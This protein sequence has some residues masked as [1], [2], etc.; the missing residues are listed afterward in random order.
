LVEG[1]VEV[2]GELKAEVKELEEEEGGT[3]VEEDVGCRTEEEA[4]TTFTV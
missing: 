4:P 1:E 3:L 2:E